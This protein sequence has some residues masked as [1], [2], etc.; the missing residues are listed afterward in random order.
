MTDR[1]QNSDYLNT[2]LQAV[3]HMAEGV[4][5]ADA[6]QP[7]MPLV[8]VNQG[9]CDMTGYQATDILGQ[10]CRFLQG[11]QTNKFV[12]E[13][14]REAIRHQDK[15]TVEL[16]NYTKAGQPFWNRLSLIPIFDD[17]GELRHYV[18][19]QSDV[20]RIKVYER[21]QDK[22]RAMRATMETV[23]DIV[24]NFLAV[25]QLYRDSRAEELVKSQA[26]L[27]KLDKHLLRTQERLDAINNMNAYKE[28]SLANGIIGLDLV[29]GSSEKNRKGH[30]T[31]P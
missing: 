19:I 6:T 11:E 14:I 29:E 21:E 25:L 31:K 7:D 3:D 20:T 26:L 28:T 15:C 9:F 22:Y 13:E 30:D 18:G 23:N 1:E 2:I 8:F 10:N 12:V 17:Q 27:T 16:L 4:S 5:V 24:V